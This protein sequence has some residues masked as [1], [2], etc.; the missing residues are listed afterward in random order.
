MKSGCCN[1]EITFTPSAFLDF[2]W[3]RCSQCELEV[4]YALVGHPWEKEHA[5]GVF[6]AYDNKLYFFWMA[7]S[8]KQSLDDYLKR[9]WKFVGVI[10]E[11]VAT[12]GQKYHTQDTDM[13]S[14][15]QHRAF[16]HYWM[17]HVENPELALK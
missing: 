13:L 15:E 17:P 11:V 1:A 4:R 14:P 2:G 10:K 8:S 9:G 16:S 12:I 5:C 6:R 7:V 3:D